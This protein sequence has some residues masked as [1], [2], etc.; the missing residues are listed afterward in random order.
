[1][2]ETITLWCVHT[3]DINT[4][5]SMWLET[6]VCTSSQISSRLNDSLIVHPYRL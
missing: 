2:G 6:T 5:V 1:M 4:T 3:L